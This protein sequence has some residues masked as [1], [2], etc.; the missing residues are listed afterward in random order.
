MTTSAYLKTFA[1][2]AVVLCLTLPKGGGLWFAGALLLFLVWA[3][4]DMVRLMLKPAERRMRV[5]RLAI[6]SLTL[7]LAGATQV[8]W[9]N[10]S[11][12]QASAAAVAVLT[13]KARTGSYPDSLDESGVNGQALQ[14]E[15]E[16]VYRLRD[17][18]PELSYP[19]PLM[20]LTLY[21]YDF[22][23]RKWTTNAY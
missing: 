14:D 21:E 18:K 3:L 4:Y 13:L 17:G 20:P 2:V 12:E 5:I 7:A 10:A 8:H 22:E 23:A 16:I 9:Q 1:L 19:A 15:W 6:W 11:R